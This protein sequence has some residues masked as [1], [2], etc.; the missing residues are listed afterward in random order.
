M[1]VW[2][3]AILDFLTLEG[4]GGQTGDIQST[5]GA[6][7]KTLGHNTSNELRGGMVVSEL[8]SQQAN[9]LGSTHGILTHS[10]FR[11][12]VL[13]GRKEKHLKGDE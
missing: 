11:I 13:K 2:E 1:L 3:D 10:A 6:P 12:C 8:S 4:A 9:T 7:P 5:F